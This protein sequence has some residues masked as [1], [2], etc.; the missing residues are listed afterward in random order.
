MVYRWRD[1][2][3]VSTSKSVDG[4]NATYFRGTRSFAEQLRTAAGAAGLYWADLERLTPEG[5]CHAFVV[6][7]P[8]T[9][10]VYPTKTPR[11][12]L[13]GTT[14]MAT[15]QPLTEPLMEH[16]DSNAE[17]GV[18][19]E[20]IAI[21]SVLLAS[22]AP[23]WAA[24]GSWDDVVA[25]ADFQGPMTPLNI[26]VLIKSSD[27]HLE[28]TFVHAKVMHRSYAAARDLVGSDQDRNRRMLEV[29]LDLKQRIA[30]LDLTP[31]LTP[32]L[33]EVDV[34]I[35]GA[36]RETLVAY[37][38]FNVN[39]RKGQP[40]QQQPQLPQPLYETIKRIHHGVYLARAKP[41]APIDYGDVDSLVRSLAPHDV[42]SLLRCCSD[43]SIRG[44]TENRHE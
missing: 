31:H 23:P 32:V 28:G 13:V 7:S 2:L 10:M 20:D 19:G 41:R 17:Y 33:R 1:E 21:T 15:L 6:Q 25:C 26:G 38:R 16:L 14:N 9:A 18:G 30:L 34:A 37:R 40:K 44:Q 11:L 39:A 42:Q 3:R 24:V 43:L 5:V 22:L 29:A 36:V 4:E 27:T 35:D 8:E 12:I